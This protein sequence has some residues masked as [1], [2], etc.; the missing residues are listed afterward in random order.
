[1]RSP[2]KKQKRK[3]IQTLDS[4]EEEEDNLSYQQNRAK[5]HSQDDEEDDFETPQQNADQ[6]E[7]AGDIN[8]DDWNLEPGVIEY[9]KVQFVLFQK[10]SFLRQLTQNSTFYCFLYLFCSE[11]QNATLILRIP[12]SKQLNV[13]LLSNHDVIFSG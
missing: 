11:N 3:R 1:M 9:V 8:L 7:G 13:E 5:R 2:S 10:H 6:N 12:H 4:D